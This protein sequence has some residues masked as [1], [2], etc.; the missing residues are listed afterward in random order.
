MCIAKDIDISQYD[1]ESLKKLLIELF[2]GY[3]PNINILLN[4]KIN[5]SEK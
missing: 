1:I 4:N 2:K 5:I 3:E